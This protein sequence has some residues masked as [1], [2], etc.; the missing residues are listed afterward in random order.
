MIT[1]WFGTQTERQYRRA[2]PPIAH[3]G[4]FVVLSDDRGRQ[5]ARCRRR[6]NPVTRDGRSAN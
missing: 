1:P 4:R 3:A 5:R 6:A 2:K